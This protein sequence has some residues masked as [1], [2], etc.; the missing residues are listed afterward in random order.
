MKDLQLQ[1]KSKASEVKGI[2]T[3]PYPLPTIYPY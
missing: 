3:F 1:G 2:K